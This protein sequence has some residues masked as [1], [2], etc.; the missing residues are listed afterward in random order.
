[1]PNAGPEEKA[2]QLHSQVQSALRCLIS[3]LALTGS[4]MASTPSSGTLTDANPKLT[5]SAGP[6][7]IPN[8]TDNVSGTPTCDTTIPAEQCDTFQLTVAVTA[9]DASSKRIKVTISFPIAAGEFDVF[10][11]DSSGNVI[12]SDT[13]GG[14]PSVATI[15]AISGTYAVVVD[16]WNPLGQ[17]FTGTVSLESIPPR[18]PP[19][20]GI[21][22]RYQVYPAPTTAGGAE[23]SASP[24]SASTGIRT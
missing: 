14:E 18:P 13:A 5:Y 20:T 17:S 24:P 16:P 1:M 6:F 23:S 15:P 7:A 8:V 3:L 11:F 4:G 19:A 9:G 2:L 12:G 22:P 10:V 21:A